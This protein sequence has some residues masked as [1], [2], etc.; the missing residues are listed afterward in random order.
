M[1][2]RRLQ[3]IE[4]TDR[5]VRA[6]TFASRRF[7]LKKDGMGFSFH[8]TILYAGMET[9]MWYR[10]HVEAVYCVEG[11]GELRVLPDGPTYSIR[12]GTM[13]ALEGHER[14]SLRAK[15]NLRMIC[16]FNPPLTGQEVHDAE[17]A[18]PLVEEAAPSPQPETVQPQ[19]TR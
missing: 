3:E 13:Y 18:Y 12:P 11:E 6:E 7:L 8:D 4:S 5:D 15:T 16:V 17:G 1:I 14:H 10:D 19:Q 9:F 2:V